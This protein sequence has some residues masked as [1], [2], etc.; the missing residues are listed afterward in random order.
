LSAIVIFV[1]ALNL[2]DRLQV[3]TSADSIWR[4]EISTV[5]A[6]LVSLW[7]GD[8][9]IITSPNGQALYAF[10]GVVMAPWPNRLEDGQFKFN[11]LELVA[12]INDVSGNNANHGL[13]FAKQFD[14]VEQGDDRITLRTSLFDADAYPFN[15][16]LQVSYELSIEGLM[17]RIDAT[18]HEA[19]PVTFATGIHPYFVTEIDSRL[20]VSAGKFLL[21][22]A[23][24]LPV[25][26]ISVDESDVIHNGS[27]LVTELDIDDCL[28]ELSVGANELQQTRLSRPAHGIEVVLSQST[29]LSHLMIFRLGE[30]VGAQRILLALEP[31]SAAANALRNEPN[32]HLLEPGQTQTYEC[33]ITTRRTA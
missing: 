23:R 3:L 31:Q 18:N 11:D 20:E 17:V 7:Q 15:I 12:P 28:T 13:V 32:S 22:S 30:T 21:K 10:A 5:G 9:E 27:N 1:S 24:G 4:A 14:T 33:T 16:E 25:G 6:A 19:Q 26:A 8:V 2:N 29:E